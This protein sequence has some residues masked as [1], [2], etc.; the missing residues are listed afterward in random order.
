MTHPNQQGP[1][2]PQQPGQQPPPPYGNPAPGPPPMQAMPAGHPYRPQGQPSPPQPA[3][4]QQQQARTLADYFRS[5]ARPVD[6]GA[7]AVLPMFLMD[8]MP[9]LWQDRM[10][11]LLDQFQ[12]QY[13][14]APWPARYRVEATEWR[15]IIDCDERQLNAV[16]IHADFADDDP[17]GDELIY[18][19]TTGE[20]IA[21]PSARRIQVPIADPLMR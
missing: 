9:P 3:Q 2:G 18:R 16:G 20:T 11:T 6:A 7:Y 21:D 8:Q 1:Q 13:S 10:V 17:D 5:E 12:Q 14:N 15:P 19:D 4:Q